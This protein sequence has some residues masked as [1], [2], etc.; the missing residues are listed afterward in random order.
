[1]NSLAP[2][3]TDLFTEELAKLKKIRSLAI[4]PDVALRGAVAAWTEF[5]VWVDNHI[6]DLI[7][8]LDKDVTLVH[9]HN[10]PPVIYDPDNA[11]RIHP[12]RYGNN[13]E[14]KEM[15]K[16]IR[17]NP[18][19]VDSYSALMCEVLM[20]ILRLEN[21]FEDGDLQ[22]DHANWKPPTPKFMVMATSPSAT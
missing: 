16:A 9:N 3:H 13:T 12:T 19:D 4:N 8:Y 14:T 21:M 20:E 18:R 15:L 7:V 5:R 2:T 17:M 1:M 6:E 22:T 10:P 11:V